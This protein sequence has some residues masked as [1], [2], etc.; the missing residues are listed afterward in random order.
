MHP[1]LITLP[2][3]DLADGLL[4]DVQRAIHFRARD[5]QGRPQGQD[6]AV[7]GLERQAA[8]ETLEHDDLGL[9]HR[10]LL[11]R[12]VFDQVDADVQ[13][14][15][16]GAGDVLY[17]CLT[18]PV[19]EKLLLEGEADISISGKVNRLRPGELIIMPANQPH[20]LKAVGRFKMMLTLI[21]T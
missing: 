2:S 19:G 20:A 3:F 11:G 12:A 17:G 15:P 18:P 16:G 6:I 13:P 5:H 10:P 8:L 1:L 21:R 4:Q 14:Q 9:V 7:D